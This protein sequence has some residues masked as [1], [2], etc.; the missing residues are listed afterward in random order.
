MPSKES[1]SGARTAMAKGSASFEPGQRD[2]HGVGRMPD[3]AGA[4][5]PD[6]DDEGGAG[7][8]SVGP[9]CG[10]DQQDIR[11]RSRV[12]T[13]VRPFELQEDVEAAG[14][15]RRPDGHA[16]APASHPLRHDASWDGRGSPAR[17][18]RTASQGST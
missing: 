17:P 11:R 15:S 4:L 5:V 9:P 13:A 7:R 12:D 6:V 16:V 8:V 3:S 14:A 10:S 1:R 2:P 18:A